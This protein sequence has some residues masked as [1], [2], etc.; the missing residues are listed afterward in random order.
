[1]AENQKFT[2]YS[3]DKYYLIVNKP[4]SIRLLLQILGY[5]RVDGHKYNVCSY[6][7]G[8][9]NFDS[10][11]EEF[12]N[13][14]SFEC[15][16][17][18]TYYMPLWNKPLL[19]CFAFNQQRLNRKS[20]VNNILYVTLFWDRAYSNSACLQLFHIPCKFYFFKFQM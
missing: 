11:M 17:F 14:G 13:S 12:F 20:R 5:K 16:R 2:S 10:S 7:Y 18:Y 8:K 3:L 4:V 15:P 1:M 6:N 19:V 9:R